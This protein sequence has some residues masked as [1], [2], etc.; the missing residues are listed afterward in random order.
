MNRRRAKK[1]RKMLYKKSACADFIA[2]MKG[3]GIYVD[4]RVAWKIARK[5]YAAQSP[6]RMKGSSEEH[7]YDVEDVF[8][9]DDE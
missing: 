8:E 1:L 7:S 5:V 6:L 4:E 3:L 2:Y 9:I